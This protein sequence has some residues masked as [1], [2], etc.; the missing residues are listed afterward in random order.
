M[1]KIAVL[2]PAVVNLI[3][4]GEVVER[5][6]SVAKELCENALDAGARHIN[7]SVLGSGLDLIRVAD[8]GAGIAPADVPIAILPH[9]TSKIASAEDLWRIRTLG[10]RGEAL[11]S[12]AA[13]SRLSILTRP[14]SEPVGYFL[15]SEG[16]VVR[17]QGSQACAPGTVVTVQELFYNTPARRRFLARPQT[18]Q[19]RIVQTVASLAL[20]R[21]DVAFRLELEGRLVL[22]TTGAADLRAA[23]AAVWG[24]ELAQACVPLAFA[25]GG[26][27]IS[28][29]VAPPA[30][31]RSERDRLVTVVN[32]RPVYSRPV[33]AAVEASYRELVPPDRRPAAVIYVDIPPEDV[34]VNVHPTKREV[35]FRD[36][37]KVREVTEEAVRAVLAKTDFV[38]SVTG[39]ASGYANTYF[40]AMPIPPMWPEVGEEAAGLLLA[41]GAEPWPENLPREGALPPL[42][43]LG[44]LAETYIVAAG[45]DGLYIIDQHAAHE[46]IMFDRLAGA[47]ASASQPLAAAV[48]VEVGVDGVAACREYGQALYD[49]GADIEPFDA[50]SVIVRSLPA[51][52]AALGPG[53]VSDLLADLGD[54]PA[55]QADVVLDSTAKY[56]RARRALAAC[57]AVTRAHDKLSPQ[58]MAD[59]ISQLRN[60]THPYACPHGRPTVIRLGLDELGRRFGR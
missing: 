12:I 48:R 27:A 10:F 25:A 55:H 17:R 35:R 19:T 20:A 1:G 16:G 26:T 22:A 53:V 39:A 5:P 45:P 28:G 7:I 37:R 18:E 29:L 42:V 13:V 21:P 38:S 50:E 3:A 34:D 31:A 15:E 14:E 56:L 24:R 9:A 41:P 46:R 60:T 43:P 47:V 33:I 52:V 32:G 23:V 40:Q 54:D 4:A 8:D 49:L 36:E 57:H 51:A 44:Q 2:P 30:M 6:A 59:L 58:E 11:A